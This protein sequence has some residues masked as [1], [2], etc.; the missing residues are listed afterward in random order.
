[1]SDTDSIVIFAALALL[2]L[3]CYWWWLSVN[4]FGMILKVRSY[5]RVRAGLPPVTVGH[6]VLNQG[7]RSLYERELLFLHDVLPKDAAV[8]DGLQLLDG[9]H[10]R[11]HLVDAY[12]AVV[13]AAPAA[14]P[15][16][17]FPAVA[18]AAPGP[19]LLEPPVDAILP[20]PPQAVRLAPLPT[21]V[22][23]LPGSQ[24]AREAERQRQDAV[25]DNEEDE[26]IRPVSDD[27]AAQWRA[28]YAARR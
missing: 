17:T 22:P 12:V 15:A 25:V 3:V 20:T 19:A 2:Q 26:E 9:A 16:P 11:R 27:Y 21:G 8:H 18:P 10:G 14:A 23:V 13:A 7:H 28:Y 24:A 1:M 6:G 5:L 4:G